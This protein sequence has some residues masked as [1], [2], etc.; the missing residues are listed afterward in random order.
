[1]PDDLPEGYYLD[2][3]TFLLDFVSRQYCHLLSEQEKQFYSTFQALTLDSRKLFVRLTNRKGPY[4]RLDKLNYPEVESLGVE[5]QSLVAAS[6]IVPTVPDLESAIRICSKADLLNLDA[7]SGFPQSTRKQDLADYLLSG[8]V[9]PV[10]ALTIEVVE[11][12]RTEELTVFKLLFFGNFHQDMT[13]FV[14]HELVAPFE[15]YE[16]DGNAGLFHCREV[17]DELIVLRSLSDASHELM[18][19]EGSE[20]DLL[21]LI[22]KL[23]AR[24]IEPVLSRR[25]DRI[26]NQIGRH[27]E[28]AGRIEEAVGVYCRAQA[29]PARERQARILDRLGKPQAAMTLCSSIIET[30]QSEEELEFA[31]RFGQRL[32]SKHGFTSELPFNLPVTKIEQ[33]TIQVSR[34]DDSV[35]MCARAY[36]QDL[37][38]ES[39]Y[40]E[41]SLIRSLFGLCFWDIIYAPVSGAFFNPFQRGPVDLYTSDFVGSRRMLISDRFKELK[42]NGPHGLATSIYREKL[43]V[44]NPFVNWTYIDEKLLETALV[45]IPSQDLIRIFERL[46]IDLKNN[47]SGFPDLIVFDQ[48]SY[49]MVEIKGPGDKLQ[50]N[51][52]RWFRYFLAHSIPAAVVNVAYLDP[53]S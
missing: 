48:N 16:I 27:L 24:N 26:V 32:G 13:T 50:K 5:I 1:M 15:Q 25:Y 20:G 35:E 22:D 52:A 44:A 37:G 42:K 10:Q 39:Y 31:Q 49:R 23:P 47:S 19:T 38:Y 45:K 18:E 12:A 36:F 40:V 6:F 33:T 11:L 4:F 43:G 14:M 3:F 21:Q 9:N 51:Q 34:L 29:T 41:N 28:R 53:V 7:C 17:I 8:Q 2:N 30:P 46:L